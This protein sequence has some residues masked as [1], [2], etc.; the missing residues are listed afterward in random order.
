MFANLT[1]AFAQTFNAITTV[2]SAANYG[3]KALENLAIVA[4][5]TSGQYVDNARS[6][7]EIK[8]IERMAAYEQAKAKAL[9]KRKEL[10]LLAPTDVEVK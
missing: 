10:A 6:D 8:Q 7:R 3:A 5:E 9:A 4:E 1:A 2:A